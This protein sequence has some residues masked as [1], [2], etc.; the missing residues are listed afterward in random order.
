MVW[1]GLNDW[2]E[3]SRE[4]L[5]AELDRLHLEL[6]TAQQEKTALKEQLSRLRQK[7]LES[8]IQESEQSY[9]L[10][11]ALSPVGIWRTDVR[12]NC[13]YANETLSK[14]TGL[15]K[16]EILGT[17]WANHVHP[18][19]RGRITAIWENFVKQSCAGQSLEYKI[20]YKALRPD[21]SIIWAL[22]EGVPE[23]SPEGEIVGFIGI[24]VDISDR[25]EMEEALRQREA[26]HRAILDAVPDLMLRVR[27]DGT[28]L[29]SIMPKSACAGTFIPVEKH[30]SEVL[31]PEFLQRQLQAIEKTLTTEEVQVYEHQIRKS[32]RIL[33]EEVRI[34]PLG[35]EEVLIL[36]CDIS[37]RKQAQRDL[38]RFFSL[39]PD[40][41]CIASFDGYFLRLNPSWEKVLG[42]TPEELMATP[43]IEFVHPE[44]RA[45]TLAEAE[46]ITRGA[47][48][49]EFENRYRC[50][51]G[52]YRWFLWTSAPYL[53][54]GANYSIAHDITD[55]KETEIALQE[56][57]QRLNLALTAANA[58]VWEWNIQ[59]NKTSHSEHLHKLF[60]LGDEG[61]GGKY[62]DFLQLV[63]PEDRKAFEEAVRDAIEK[64]HNYDIEFRVVWPDGTFHW[65][66]SRGKVLYD[67]TGQPLR[68][69]GVDKDVSGRKQAE[70]A[71]RLAEENYR[72][73]FENA[74]G[75]IFQSTPEGRY[76]RVNP[77]MA[78][79]H[80]YE[81]PEEMMARISK[82]DRQIYVN[83]SEREAF[84][85]SIAEKGEL[86]GFQYQ[87][88]K[89]DGRIIWL[90]ENTRIV[91]GPRGEFLYY[92]GIV[93][94]I[95]QRKQEEQALKRKVEKLTIEIDQQRRQR[96]VAEIMQSEHFREIQA[97]IDK[98]RSSGEGI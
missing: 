57:Q 60:G 93:Q 56:S 95:T 17:G 38:D 30:L 65:I 83:P 73:I 48:V 86:K 36:V 89:A 91:R 79:I 52:S 71:L 76:L 20:E 54:T 34:S 96:E 68:M 11:T 19:D 35:E 23:Y 16:T 51:D 69:L 27:R 22:G 1:E 39:S 72:S 88:Q 7:N 5:F 15:S 92:E 94:D 74:L 9:R 25:K 29:E 59:T 28:C 55:R 32:D 98:L 33:D 47:R 62:E 3:L 78:R 43:Y 2:G 40:L 44:D 87:V 42:Y 82:I 80:G 13:I 4:Q 49:I 31:P 50:R 70:E 21:G 24:M 63:H 37:Q 90:E 18:E 26:N 8:P 67:K 97:E 14:L 46:K 45:K 61:F 53:E 81:S 58:G 12:G 64:R 10:L 77:A 85:R 75:G 84:L 66:S 41:L 6:A